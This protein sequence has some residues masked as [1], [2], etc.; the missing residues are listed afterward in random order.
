M[1]HTLFIHNRDNNNIQH[2][3]RFTTTNHTTNDNITMPI[4]N[5]I[6]NNQSG[7]KKN[8]RDKKRLKKNQ[9]KIDLD[10]SLYK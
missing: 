2:N 3:P 1:V 4:H 6:T 5:R 9:T 8:I 7:T 10:R